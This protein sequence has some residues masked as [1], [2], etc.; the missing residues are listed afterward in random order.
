L[1]VLLINLREDRDLVRRTIRSRGYRARTLL[2]TSGRAATDYG[3]NGTPTV[4]LV[5]RSGLVAGRAIGRREWD[6]PAAR[7]L[8]D[9]LLAS[10]RR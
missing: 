3:V 4:F 2:D 10:D 5:A 8:I 9:A 6:S 1:E 7:A